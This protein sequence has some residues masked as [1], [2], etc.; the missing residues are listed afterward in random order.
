MEGTWRTLEL[1]VSS[2]GRELGDAELAVREDVV[3][4][5][6][7]VLGEP[8]QV[9]RCDDCLLKHWINRVV[10]SSVVNHHEEKRKALDALFRTTTSC[11]ASTY[12]GWS[13]GNQTLLSWIVLLVDVSWTVS[14]VCVSLARNSL[15][16]P[17]P[18]IRAVGEPKALLYQKA[19]SRLNKK[20]ETWK[21]S[22]RPWQTRK[23]IRIAESFPL[24]LCEKVAEPRVTDCNGLGGHY[25]VCTLP[26]INM[27]N[28]GRT[29]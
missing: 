5:Q 19:R 4:G 17:T 6:R 16:Q 7:P 21:E 28:C 13:S 12:R 26:T 27:L 2:K 15:T 8:R 24:F 14:G 20:D 1:D 11:V 18:W 3:V 29:S 10:E 25:L 23:Y 22:R 9:Q